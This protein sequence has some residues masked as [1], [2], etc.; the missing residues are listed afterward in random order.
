MSPPRCSLQLTPTPHCRERRPSPL[1]HLLRHEQ[2][3]G[4]S[5]PPPPPPPPAHTLGAGDVSTAAAG[6]SPPS[7]SRDVFVPPQLFPPASPT[8]SRTPRPA[9]TPA[10]PGS[11]R[12]P[13]AVHHHH[14]LRFIHGE[15]SRRAERRRRRPARYVVTGSLARRRPTAPTRR[16][17]SPRVRGP[18]A[19]EPPRDRTPGRSSVRRRRARIAARL[20]CPPKICLRFSFP[21]R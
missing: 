11:R 19:I 15:S 13:R 1:A 21:P 17:R 3:Q 4:I 16:P 20:A 14:R 2:T 6:A 12:R 7:L 18:G 10:R 8:A 9:P 5:S